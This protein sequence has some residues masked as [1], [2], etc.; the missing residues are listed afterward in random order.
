MS[1]YII[2]SSTMLKLE[3]AKI[4]PVRCIMRKHCIRESSKHTQEKST[5]NSVL[6]MQWL[7]YSKGTDGSY[8]GSTTTV[9]VLGIT[10]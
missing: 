2:Y 5:R 9:T 10:A 3:E 7:Y 4:K 6:P 1:L 8:I